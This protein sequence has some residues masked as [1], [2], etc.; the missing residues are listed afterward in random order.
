M[1]FLW[2]DIP[3]GWSLPI[4]F[5]QENFEQT[6]SEQVIFDSKL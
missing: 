6:S 2:T 1:E 5:K 3:V 4:T